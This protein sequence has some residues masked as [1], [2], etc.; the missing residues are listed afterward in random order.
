[1]C[2]EGSKLGRFQMI[3]YYL[4]MGS[5][6]WMLATPVVGL[7]FGSYLYLSSTFFGIHFDESFSSLRIPNYKAITRMHVREDGDLEI[8]SFALPPVPV[9]G[10][11]EDPRWG[12]PGHL[13]RWIPRG[14]SDT[15][16]LHL[17]DFVRV[18]K[19]S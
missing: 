3:F 8:F 15:E 10:W 12:R 7:V 6:F 13:S 9:Q 4:G 14:G 17:I 5:F 19:I 18:A 2:G 11:K 1:M 16:P